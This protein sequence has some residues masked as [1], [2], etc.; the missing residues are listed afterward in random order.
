VGFDAGSNFYFS[1]QKKNTH[2]LGD[3]SGKLGY[4][5]KKF[6]FALEASGSY[7]HIML[8]QIG[9]YYKNTAESEEESEIYQVENS[10]KENVKVK[11]AARADFGWKATQKDCFNAFY[12]YKYDNRRPDTYTYSAVSTEEYSISCEQANNLKQTHNFGISYTR[13]FEKPERKLYADIRGEI[14]NSH[15]NSDWL[16]DSLRYRIQP[17]SDNMDAVWRTVFTEPEFA[18]VK[19]LTLDFAFGGHRNSLED[20]CRASTLI[21][22]EWRDSTSYR[23]NFRFR[24]LRVTPA[25]RVRY[26]VGLYS[27][28]FDYAPEYYAYKL[29]SDGHVGDVSV[30]SV[31]HQ[32]NMTNTF[33]PWNGHEFVLGFSREEERPEYLQVCWFVRDGQYADEKYK[34]NPDLKNSVTTR[35][36]LAY[37]YTKNRFE[38]SFNSIYTYQPRK[39]VKTYDY[40]MINDQECRV[41]TWINGGKSHEFNEILTFSWTGK[42]FKAE[43]SGEY[44]FYK[45]FSHT[46]EETTSSEYA[47][48]ANAQYFLKKWTF[49]VGGGYQSEI[50]RT[51]VGRSA[52]PDCSL[53]VSKLFGKHILLYLEAKALLDREL[54]TTTESEDKTETRVETYYN[55]NRIFILGFKYLFN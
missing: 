21:N 42:K 7:H 41:Y 5:G 36:N 12:S 51:F 38:T 47:I 31:A 39:I 54:S 2:N 3:V 53:K 35:A 16:A 9:H 26:S 11:A 8:G 33:T 37:T 50:K 44:T 17:Y 28:D 43:L 46:G 55:N 34:G 18:G 6:S 20:H 49:S 30:G 25:V 24:T 45:G 40:E 13:T 27:L 1:P 29:D 22:Q 48:A 14:G 10:L 4:E 52:I 32:I 23:E 19:N 15:E